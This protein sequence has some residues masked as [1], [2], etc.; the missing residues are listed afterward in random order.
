[1]PFGCDVICK[2]TIVERSWY[3]MVAARRFHVLYLTG[4]P[5]T[6][7]STLCVALKRNIRGLEVFAYSE[8][9]RS[10]VAQ[11]TRTHLT[12]NQ[13]REKS[14]QVIST[15]DVQAVDRK[16]S[17]LVAKLRHKRHFVID[18][19]AVT[20]EA[21]GYRVTAFTRNRLKELS[22]TLIVV[23]YT[24]GTEARKRIHGNAGGRPMPSGFEADF[25]TTLQAA[26]AFTYAFT[27]G[28]PIYYLDASKT[29][30]QL[31]RRIAQMLEG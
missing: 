11:R 25:H 15:K 30:A 20:K 13:I 2:S 18:S 19:H 16:L 12:E 7:K 3:C 4:A 29:T 31:A 1:M 10:Y 9:L 17:N 8:E 28:C 26:V 5:A 6:G 24:N 14:A 21:Y 23:L 22:P 27:L